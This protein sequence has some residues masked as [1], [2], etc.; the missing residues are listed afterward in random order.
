MSNQTCF[1]DDD[2][3]TAE[4]SPF[5]TITSCRIMKDDKGASRGFGFVCYSSPDEAS[6]AVSELNG[7]MIGTKPLYVSLAQPKDV[8]QKQ[9]S[10]QAAQQ[11]Q[12]RSQQMVRASSNRQYTKN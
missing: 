12:I 10:A 11:E 7:K 4:F 5:G 3:L 1:R 9:L 8:R 2:K 6:K